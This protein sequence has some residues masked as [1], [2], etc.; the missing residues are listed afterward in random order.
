[1]FKLAELFVNIKAQD[2][3]FQSSIG[4]LKGQIT[5]LGVAIGTAVGNL[6]TSAIRAATYALGSF[7]SVG[8]KGSIELKDNVSMVGA[9][10]DDSAAIILKRADE[11]AAK[12]GT[13]KGEFITAAAG[14]GSAFKSVGKSQE[15]AAKLGNTLAELGMDLASFKGSSNAEAFTALTAALRGEFDPL[16]KY[17]I[18]L[19][20]AAVENEAMSMGLIKSSK[21]MDEAA[22]KAATLSLI[23]KK[24]VDQQGD[25][26]ARPTTR[27]M[28]GENSPAR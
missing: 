18:M 10:F 21:D 28:P 11:L 15:D 20:A 14:F 22:K 13:I 3:A 16:E 12:F 23:M 7:F 8:V 4:A 5:T 6:A 1:M 19:S 2:S 17:N 27:V 26:A 9:V 25:L 24:S